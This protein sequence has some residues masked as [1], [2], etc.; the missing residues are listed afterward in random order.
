SYQYD[1][2]CLF[3]VNLIHSAKFPVRSG[4]DI[5]DF[6]TDRG[7]ELGHNGLICS[8]SKWSK[9]VPK[10]F[11]IYNPRAFRKF[12]IAIFCSRKEDEKI[13]F[14]CRFFTFFFISHLTDRFLSLFVLVNFVWTL[15]TW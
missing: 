7:R 3:F 4:M 2:F 15:G 6:M 5:L 8:A 1:R 14:R 9:I 12:D 11:S 13:I 10:N